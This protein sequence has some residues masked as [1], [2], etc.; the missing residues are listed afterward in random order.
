MTE[1]KTETFYVPDTTYITIPVERVSVVVKDSTSHLEN[2]YAISDAKINRDGTLHHSLTTKP[3]KVEVPFQKPII[4]KDSI[5]TRVITKTS[6]QKVEIEK[7]KSW[8]D[9][10]KSYGFYILVILTLLRY[11]KSILKLVTAFNF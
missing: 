7:P 1:I 11:R 8:W 5:K 10:T 2:D 9:K 6:I 4:T 3:K